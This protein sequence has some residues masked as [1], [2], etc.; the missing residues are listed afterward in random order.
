MMSMTTSVSPRIDERPR[1]LHELG[2]VGEVEARSRLVEDRKRALV[3]RVKVSSAES[4]RRWGLA[5][6]REFV[7]ALAE[8]DVAAPRSTRVRSGAA[9]GA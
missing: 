1:T 7:R 2:D 8:L 5:S 9:N 6:R 4:L 3:A